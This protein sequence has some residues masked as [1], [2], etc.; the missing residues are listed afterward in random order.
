MLSPLTVSFSMSVH[1][2]SVETVAVG[3][4][5]I[6]RLEQQAVAPGLFVLILALQNVFQMFRVQHPVQCDG[7]APAVPGIT[8]KELTVGHV[9]NGFAQGFFSLS[10]FLFP[11]QRYLQQR[12]IIKIASP[13]LIIK[14]W[15]Y[16][17]W[18]SLT[19][20]SISNAFFWSS[21]NRRKRCISFRSLSVNVLY[22]SLSS[23]IL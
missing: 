4:L 2:R 1:H 7:P 12:I 15:C 18:F 3:R 13:L 8:Q 19:C 11:L 14:W 20:R 6:P 16:F 22:S 23:K 5:L 9:C 10:L 21:R 17:L